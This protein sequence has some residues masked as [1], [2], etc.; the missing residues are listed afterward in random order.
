[1][2]VYIHIYTPTPPENAQKFELKYY[3]T[4]GCFFFLGGRGG[5]GGRIFLDIFSNEKRVYSI[6]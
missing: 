5:R 2:Y 1:M 6:I 4:L 3:S